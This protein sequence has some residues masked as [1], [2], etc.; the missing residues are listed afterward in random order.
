MNSGQPAPNRVD[1]RLPWSPQPTQDPPML[2]MATTHQ[3]NTS[4]P[5]R[6]V[7]RANMSPGSS[8]ATETSSYSG[9]KRSKDSIP[10]GQIGSVSRAIKPRRKPVPLH[11]AFPDGTAETPPP[12]P[13]PE[14]SLGRF[15]SPASPNV[16]LAMT[17]T[18]WLPPVGESTDPVKSKNRD[19]DRG[20]HR[21]REWDRPSDTHARR[22]SREVSRDPCDSRQTCHAGTLGRESK[23]RLDENGMLPEASCHRR[24]RIAAIHCHRMEGDIVILK[25]DRI[26]HPSPFQP[27]NFRPPT[28]VST[29]EGKQPSDEPSH[30]ATGATFLCSSICRS[31]PWLGDSCA[32]QVQPT[33]RTSARTC[34]VAPAARGKKEARG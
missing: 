7:S 21:G 26:F 9:R 22:T 20:D 27:D 15:T 14:S 13:K 29:A 33:R 30:S 6:R 2:Q 11:T 1:Y 32:G 19:R 24:H 28:L 31:R 23:Q 17:Y 18:G 10:G 5:S 12:T 34:S 25:V 16:A 4:D 3:E 8:R